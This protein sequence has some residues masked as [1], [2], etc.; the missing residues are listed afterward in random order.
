MRNEEII[1]RIIAHVGVLSK[2]CSGQNK[3]VKIVSCNDGSVK[4]Y[5]RSWSTNH[6]KRLRGITLSS[7]EAQKLIDSVKTRDTVGMLQEI[8]SSAQKRALNVRRLTKS[9]TQRKKLRKQGRC[10]FSHISGFTSLK[11]IVCARGEVFCTREHDSLKISNGKQM[12]W[13]RGFDGASDLDY[14]I[15][16][17]GLSFKDAMEILNGRKTNPYFFIPQ[18]ESTQ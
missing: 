11:A 10:I 2:D 12:W 16:V 1:C 8:E 17:K 18:K 15:K 9:T 13:S 5:I 4:I 14:L 7:D 3:E 6:E